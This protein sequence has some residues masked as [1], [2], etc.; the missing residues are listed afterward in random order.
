MNK[1]IF[2]I[3][4]FSLLTR[5]IYLYLD[6]NL[7]W[8][9]AVYISMGKY[10]S[11]MGAIGLWEPIRPLFWPILLAYGNFI[12]A[13][14]ILWGHI[15]STFF[16]LACIYLTYLIANKLFNEK[17]A[18]FSSLLLSFT[19]I[20]FFFNARLYTEIPAVFFALLAYY[21]F[22]K[23]KP[24]ETGI[25]T[26]FSFLTKFPEG[27]ILVIFLLFSFKSFKK[28][29]WILLGFTL[30]II[31]YF[32][33]NYFAYGSSMQILFFAQEFLNYAG[34]WIF[35]KPWWWYPIALV[36]DNILLLFVLPGIVFAL[37]KK[38]Y[39]LIALAIIPLIYF[40]QMAH[41]ELRFAILFLPFLCILAAYGYIKT[42]KEESSFIIL[43]FLI[44][45]LAFQI[46]LAINNDY[47]TYFEGK[48]IHG[49]TLITHPL[50]SVYINNISTM[51]YYPWFN[52]SQ[53]EYWK[54]YIEKNNP[55]YISLDTCEGGFLCPPDD[56]ICEEKQKELFE[57]INTTYTLE[58]SSETFTCT[59]LIYILT[60][61]ISLE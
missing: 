16:S 29:F 44:F 26:A 36:Q 37:Y 35:T 7:W 10:L 3:L 21:C 61:N 60:E 54:E 13:N 40:S 58:W 45:L 1:K 33:F 49:E 31:P 17:T 47:F 6:H 9:A 46:E 57:A 51:M 5:I 20:F 19:W 52:S 28:I 43:T 8:D 15:F 56:D 48:E 11:T 50:S 22:L 32:A 41:K 30:T 34:I 25:F 27:V 59:Y 53:A 4:F 23:E 55:K 24:F 18:V 38:R 14:I 2:I 39:S 42:L 12:G